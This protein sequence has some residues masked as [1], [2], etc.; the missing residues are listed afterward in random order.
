MCVCLCVCVCVCLCVCV[1]VC[2][3]MSPSLSLIL[4][5]C[6]C[7]CVCVCVCVCVYAEIY[8]IGVQYSNI[9]SFVIK[10]T[11]S[12]WSSSGRICGEIVSYMLYRIC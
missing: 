7:L 1:N 11:V 9:F 10:L 4:S 8:C 5:V 6:V 12:A 3:C 2:V